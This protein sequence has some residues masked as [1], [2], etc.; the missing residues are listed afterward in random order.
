MALKSSEKRVTVETAVRQENTPPKASRVPR[1]GVLAA[2]AWAAPT[3]AVATAAPAIAASPPI[4]PESDLLVD[5]LG[6]AEGRYGTGN[7]YTDGV[8]GPNT[9]FRRAFSVT[10]T[11]DG[12]FT[13]SLRIDFTFPR[14]WNQAT[15]TNTD[16]FSNWSTQDL[17][18]TGGGSIGGA[19]PWGLGAEATTYTQNT[20]NYAWE[21]VWLR[22]DPAYFTLTNVS[23]P[24]GATIWFAL[25]ARVPDA[26]IGDPGVYINPGGPNH[27]YWRSEVDITAT[28][29][30]GDDLG[31]YRTP[32]GD[33][34]DGIWYFNGG[35]PFAYDGGQGLYPA[36]GTA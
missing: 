33:W 19:S 10:N 9:D 8:K 16:A 11:G 34:E 2:A 28:T 23:L 30:G 1:R 15:G 20:G 18:G 21:A 27:I 31:T 4:D 6:G 5:A 25:N 12:S 29:T 26:W 14:M 32:V 13:G 22:N 17:G 24:P 3:L 7:S 35:G 36:H